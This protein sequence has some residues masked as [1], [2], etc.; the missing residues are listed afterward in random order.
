M[1]ARTGVRAGRRDLHG[2]PV[3]TGPAL[4]ARD[5]IL[6]ESLR[7]NRLKG[8]GR[9][10]VEA[11]A[12]GHYVGGCAVS[13]L[14]F[15]AGLFMRSFPCFAASASG[16]HTDTRIGARAFRFRGTLQDRDQISSFFRHCWGHLK[17]IPGCRR[18]GTSTC[19]RMGEFAATWR[20]PANRTE[21]WYS[22]LQLCSEDYFA[23]LRIHFLRAEFLGTTTLAISVK[24]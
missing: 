19:L 7:E 1:N 3:W 23:V 4:Q 17:S 15:T 22:L 11:A 8:P 6:N 14:L 20:S 2:V 5:A 13:T 10:R 24:W 12:T 21:K 16:L 9:G 18:R